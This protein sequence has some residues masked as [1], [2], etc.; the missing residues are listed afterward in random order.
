MKKFVYI[1]GLSL[2]LASCTKF[3][4]EKQTTGLQEGLYDTETVLESHIYG[5]LGRFYGSTGYTGEGT[6]FLNLCCPLIHHGLESTTVRNTYYIS[7]LDYT[8]YS[9]SGKNKNFFRNVFNIVNACNVLIANLPDSPVDTVYKR[10]IMA[11]ARFYRAF[12][13]FRLVRTWGDVPIR[14]ETVNLGNLNAVRDPYYKV[15]DFIIEDLKYAQKNMRSPQRVEEVTPN[16]SRVNKYAAT[17]FLSTVYCTIGSLLTSQD[18][19][20]WNND[21]KERQPAFTG[22]ESAED[23]YALALEEAEKLIPGSTNYDAGCNYALADNYGDLFNWDSIDFPEVYTLKERIFVLPITNGLGNKNVTFAEFTLPPYAEGTEFRDDLV[24]TGRGRWR[25]DRWTYQHWCEDYPGVKGTG[26]AANVWDSSS[27]PR[28]DYTLYHTKVYNSQTKTYSAVYPN[29][30]VIKSNASKKHTYPFFRKYWSRRYSSDSGEADMYLMRYAEVY[31]NAAEA[32]AE[33]GNVPL[34]HKYME[35]IHSRARKSAPVGQTATMPKWNDDQYTT[36]KEL[37][38]QI[39]WERIYETFGENHEFD[40]THRHGAT[41]L[42]EQ[43]SAPMNAFLELPEQARLYK[44]DEHNSYFYP[45]PEPYKY[46][47]DVQTARKGLLWDYPAT[48]LNYN[49]ALTINNQNDYTYGL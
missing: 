32:A 25:P 7:A 44:T 4:Q 46:V 35:V 5:I 36:T 9:S 12:A 17:A 48:E 43:L 6:E 22:I 15:Y 30:D 38:N 13:Y 19:N 39:F 1:L 2:C 37:R 18:D 16:K 23:A 41:W 21:K 47:T 29:P 26:K 8:Q 10:E 49:D 42:C 45:G 28:F 20:F 27:D 11:E 31:L 34:A 24:A 3:L 40:E 14:R 33:L